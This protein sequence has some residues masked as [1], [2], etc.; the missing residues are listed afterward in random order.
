MKRK[1]LFGIFRE[2]ESCL[3][4]WDEW[5]TMPAGSDPMPYLSRSKTPMPFYQSSSY[6][7]CVLSMAGKSLIDLPGAI[8]DKVMMDIGDIVYIPAGQKS[9]IIPETETI[10]IRYRVE[11]NSWEAVSWLCSKCQSE[12]FRHEFDASKTPI[13]RGYQDGCDAFNADV[14]H[15]TCGECGTVAEPA[16]LSDIKWRDVLEQVG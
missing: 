7:Q 13:Q 12:L 2:S 9:R 16:D 1:K 4:S 10:T 14:G 6:D 5:P 8:P 3:G 11:P 15:R